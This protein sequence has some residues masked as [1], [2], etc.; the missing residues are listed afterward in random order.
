M[1]EDTMEVTLSNLP[2]SQKSPIQRAQH[3]VVQALPELSGA[4]G[5]TA[6]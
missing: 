1:L 6:S 3:V 5:L 4:A 2:L